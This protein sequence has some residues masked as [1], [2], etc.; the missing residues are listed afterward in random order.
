[1]ATGAG[2]GH[3]ASFVGRVFRTLRRGVWLLVV[4]VLLGFNLA[5]LT[6]ASLN[7][8]VSGALAAVS[9]VQTVS[10]G[11][12]RDKAVLGSRAK[13]LEKKNTRLARQAQRQAAVRTKSKSVVRRVQRRVALGATRNV[14]SIAAESIPMAGIAVVLGVTAL[15]LKDACDTARDLEELAV[16]LGAEEPDAEEGTA[17]CG[18]EMPSREEITARV[19]E[20]SG[21]AW[22]SAAEWME[23]AGASLP[24]IDDAA[25]WWQGVRLCRGLGWMPWNPLCDGPDEPA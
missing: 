5:T 24:S 21:A 19:A 20:S 8:A 1:M 10:Q 23:E 13:A 17:V 6:I 22:A 7:M 11:L 15:E 18:L 3:G 9:G 12:R 4:V 16:A 25:E 2:P 14:G